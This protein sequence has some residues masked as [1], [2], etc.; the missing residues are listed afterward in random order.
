MALTEIAPPVVPTMTDSNN[1]AH[2]L[3]CGR[4]LYLTRC[5]RCHVAPAVRKYSQAE[6]AYW[7]PE[8][9]RLSKLN[10]LQESELRAYV[11]AVIG[12]EGRK[13]AE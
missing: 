4:E 11:M 13:S 9:S 3:S 6:W 1:D 5:A 12:G 8:M 7:L 10:N 2:F